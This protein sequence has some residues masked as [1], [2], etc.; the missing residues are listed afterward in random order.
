MATPHHTTP[1]HT[2]RHHTTPII[3]QDVHPMVGSHIGVGT[4]DHLYAHT[5]GYAYTMPLGALHSRMLQQQLGIPQGTIQGVHVG[6]TEAIP[7]VKYVGIAYGAYTAPLT[8]HPMMMW[9]DDTIT[10]LARGEGR[11]IQGVLVDHCTYFHRVLQASVPDKKMWHGS[12]WDPKPLLSPAPRTWGVP[13]SHTPHK[14]RNGPCNT[15]GNFCQPR[16]SDIFLQG[17]PTAPRNVS[18][19]GAE[20]WG[21]VPA[22]DPRCGNDG[23]Q[24]QNPAQVVHHGERVA[25]Y[26]YNPATK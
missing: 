16:S 1:Y 2:T 25:P 15:R 21:Q 8:A 4:R 12:T 9:V 18:A 3:A 20:I 26:S 17:R 22:H 6:A 10:V 24:G 23:A 5:E 11:P 7:F 14:P 13:S 19:I